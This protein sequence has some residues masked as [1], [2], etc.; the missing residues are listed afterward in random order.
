MILKYLVAPDVGITRLDRHWILFD[1][2]CPPQLLQI[3]PTINHTS[4]HSLK[5]VCF[6]YV[7]ITKK[8][9]W[10]KLLSDHSCNVCAP[11]GEL[12]IGNKYAPSPARLRRIALCCREV[13]ITPVE[14]HFWRTPN[15]WTRRYVC[16]H[17]AHNNTEGKSWAFSTRLFPSK[18]SK[19]SPKIGFVLFWF[20]S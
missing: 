16:L 17:M 4:H 5:I 19:F 6:Q 9:K 3:D 20:L 7:V 8:R 14:L 1:I 11:A 10:T 13:H 12:N 15:F 2:V 18:E